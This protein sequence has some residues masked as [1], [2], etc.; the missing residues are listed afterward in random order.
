M[1]GGGFY[2]VTASFI[3]KVLQSV[4]VALTQRSGRWRVDSGIDLTASTFAGNFGN[5]LKIA[6]KFLWE[7]SINRLSK[8]DKEIRNAQ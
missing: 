2:H 8:G 5:P 4:E 6:L 3:G 1:G 7:A